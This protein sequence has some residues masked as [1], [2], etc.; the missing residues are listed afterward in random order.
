MKVVFVQIC[1]ET[2]N[3]KPLSFWVSGGTHT[4]PETT[5]APENGWLEDWFPFGMAC[6][7]V[8]AS[9]REGKQFQCFLSKV[10]RF[11][12]LPENPENPE[13]RQDVFRKQVVVKAPTHPKIGQFLSKSCKSRRRLNGLK[14]QFERTI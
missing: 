12:R 11:C 5:I 9:F 7:Q 1:F 8:H 14:E 4:L 6:F 13:E 2:S 3:R 10:L